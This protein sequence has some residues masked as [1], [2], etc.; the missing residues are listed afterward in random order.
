MVGSP[1]SPEIVVAAGEYWPAFAE[2]DY[3]GTSVERVGEDAGDEDG[4]G[5]R[6]KGKLR[7]LEGQGRLLRRP[8]SKCS[9]DPLHL[10]QPPSLPEPSEQPVDSANHCC[11][12]HCTIAR[13]SSTK[14]H[15]ISV[16]PLDSQGF[17]S[18]VLE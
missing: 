7:S 12:D 6:K 11:F 16:A 9:L 14:W 5:Q 8:K 17:A 10:V 2:V 15:P 4:S 1:D 18:T 3:S 13:G